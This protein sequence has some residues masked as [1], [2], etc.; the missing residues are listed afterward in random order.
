MCTACVFLTVADPAATLA[1]SFSSRR[2]RSPL[3]G[4]GLRRGAVGRLDRGVEALR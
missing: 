4:D 1:T 2:M 3:A